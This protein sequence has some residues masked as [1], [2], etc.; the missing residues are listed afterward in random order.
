[1][2]SQKKIEMVLEAC[3]IVAVL[4]SLFP[5]VS[6]VNKADHGATEV[7]VNSAPVGN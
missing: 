2:T 4:I 5:L 6:A 7:P 1:M 3:L